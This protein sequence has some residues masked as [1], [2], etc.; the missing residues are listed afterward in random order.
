[1]ATP[2]VAGIVAMIRQAAPTLTSAEVRTKLLESALDGVVIDPQ[3]GSPNELANVMGLLGCDSDQENTD[4]QYSE[5]STWTTCP[6]ITE[7]CGEPKSTR[8]RTVD[9][10]S[11]C[12]GEPCDFNALFEEEACP[13]DFPRCR[14]VAPTEMVS[15]LDF[16]SLKFIPDG[17]SHYT[18]CEANDTTLVD[19]STHSTHSLGD[20]D[21][22]NIGQFT[23]KFYSSGPVTKTVYVGSNGYI[24]FG[25]G[26]TAWQPTISAH[27]ALP[28]L[29]VMF[30]DL[31]PTSSQGRVHT[32]QDSAKIVVTWNR[33]V[34][35]GSS[36]VNTFQAIIYASGELE[37]R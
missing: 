3:P 2:L 15:N 21:F 25:S 28:R 5:W 34:Y 23:L 8:E 36:T 32:Y 17:D 19:F 26:D 37:A 13:G 27:F 18:V 9:V 33:L 7:G 11:S 14:P 31:D 12:F 10:Q 22:V 30:V 4:C 35:Y 24:T 20:D 6:T 16:S 29:S 1:M